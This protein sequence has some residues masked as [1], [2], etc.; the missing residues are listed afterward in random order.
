MNVRDFAILYMLTN[1]SVMQHAEERI[2]PQILFYY[3]V[4]RFQNFLATTEKHLIPFSP[5][6]SL[7]LLISG[8][9]ERYSNNLFS[10]GSHTKEDHWHLFNILVTYIHIHKIMSLRLNGSISNQLWSTSTYFEKMLHIM[11]FISKPA[12]LFEVRSNL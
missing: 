9:Q 10:I 7:S 2:M 5:Y 12:G 6:S 3:Q 4:V 11:D 8:I 1:R